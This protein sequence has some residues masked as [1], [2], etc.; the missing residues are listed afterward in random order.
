MIIARITRDLYRG[1][2]WRAFLQPKFLAYLPWLFLQ[3]IV[4]NLQV[5]WVVLHPKLPISPKLVNFKTGLKRPI[6]K[7]ALAN[8]ITLT[9][10]TVTVD[11]N[12][13]DFEVHALMKSSLSALEEKDGAVGEMVDRIQSV[14]GEKS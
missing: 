12:G 13:E 4:A 9:P 5:A 3:I 1:T 14:F 10:G 11:V 7:L 6:A 8:S 2:D